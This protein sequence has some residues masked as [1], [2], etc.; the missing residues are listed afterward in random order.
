LFPIFAKG[1]VNGQDEQAIFTFLKSSC[2]V[3]LQIMNNPAYIDWSPVRSYDI[4]WNFAKVRCF[5]VLFYF[6]IVL[7]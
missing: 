5:F 7:Y 2:D 6:C 1:H 4:T 3:E